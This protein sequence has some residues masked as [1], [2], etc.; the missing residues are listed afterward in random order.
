MAFKRLLAGLGFGGA[1]VETVMEDAVAVPGGV[2]RGQ[3]HIEG[4]T[5][6]QQV[7]ELTVG[8]QTRV[9]VESG[10]NEYSQDM[11]FCRQRLGGALH[12]HPGARYTVPFE[13]RVPFETPV[14]W[15]RGTV[16]HPM[17]LG[18]NTRLSV[19][20]AIDPGDLDPVRVGPLPSQQAVLDALVSLG[21]VVK[22]TDMERGQL[23]GTRQRLPFY[24]EIEFHAPSRYRGLNDLE[25]SFATDERGADVVVELD[26][27]PGLLGER[28][29]S[30]FAFSFDHAT[31]AHQDW[32]GYL[33]AQIDAIAGRRG[34]L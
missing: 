9:E 30:Y 17:R 11:E 24:Q 34:W 32:A 20:G 31:A 14:N 4:G 10:D 16:L 8:L 29:D 23:R 7:E 3:V 18:V 1:S 5:V 33:H 22:H 19:A 2:L 6:D 25:L 28:S 21:F 13:L 26:R 27:R 15:Y 12:L